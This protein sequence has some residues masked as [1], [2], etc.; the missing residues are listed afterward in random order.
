MLIIYIHKYIYNWPFSSCSLDNNFYNLI[1]S[2][3]KNLQKEKKN[4]NFDHRNGSRGN[5]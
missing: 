2:L 4:L 5:D 3:L 1:F